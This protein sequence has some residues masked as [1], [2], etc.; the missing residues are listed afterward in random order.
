VTLE[1]GAAVAPAAAGLRWALAVLAAAP[2]AF[3]I[4]R[5]LQS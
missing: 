4:E 3:V 2:L 5:A 1:G